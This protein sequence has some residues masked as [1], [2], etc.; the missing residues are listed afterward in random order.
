LFQDQCRPWEPLIKRYTKELFEAATALLHHVLH[1]TA[2]ATTS[3]GIFR[4]ILEPALEP[5]KA[6]LDAKASQILDQHLH[7]HPITFN[8]YL[9]DNI[10]KAKDSHLKKM[11]AQKLE[12]FFQV[13]PLS[14]KPHA[15]IKTDGET[16]TARINT[17]GLL[18]VL[19]T[20][21]EVEMKTYACSEALACME[22][23]YKV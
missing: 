20:S 7:N 14:S 23:Y 9:T 19:T 6:T 3:Q 4:E 10:Q 2:D 22:A 8:K 17:K 12:S 18:D 16:G 5:L 11:M 1:F 15:N 21:N 13:D